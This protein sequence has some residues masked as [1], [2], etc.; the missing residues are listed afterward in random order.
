MLELFGASL[1]FAAA[2]C[3]SCDLVAL[4]RMCYLHAVTRYKRKGDFLDVQVLHFVMGDVLLGC[5][6]DISDAVL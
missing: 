6:N 4:V 1:V 3:Y 5:A 2:A